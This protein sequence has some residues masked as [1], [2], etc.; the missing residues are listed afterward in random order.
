MKRCLGCQCCFESEKWDC[1]QCGRRPDAMECCVSSKMRLSPATDSSR[2]ILQSS[3]P[4]RNITSGFARG[5]GS[6]NRSVIIF[7]MLQTSL[8]LAVELDSSFEACERPHRE[9]AWQEAR[10][11]AMVWSLRGHVCL[12][13]IY[14]KWMRARSLSSMRSMSSEHSTFLNTSPRMI[15]C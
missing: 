10:F 2:N 3:R 8:R 15:W 6:S 4:L 5:I 1:P 11:L 13:R 14:T 9:Y 12:R 7:P